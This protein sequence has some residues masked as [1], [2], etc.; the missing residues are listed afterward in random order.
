MTRG[1]EL[2]DT[3]GCAA[4]HV[5]VPGQEAPTYR[6]LAG[7]GAKYSIDTLSTFLRTPQP[8][9]PA[10]PFPDDQRRALAIYLLATYP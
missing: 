9:M 8:P 10:Y 2:W 6:R 7:L 1:K 5:Q 4:C 3:S